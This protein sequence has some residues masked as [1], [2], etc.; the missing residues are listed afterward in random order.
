MEIRVDKKKTVTRNANK[1]NSHGT[2][3]MAFALSSIIVISC[4]YSTFTKGSE[5]NCKMRFSFH[6]AK[7]L[8][9]DKQYV[10]VDGH[11]C[12][13]YIGLKYLVCKPLSRKGPET[14]TGW[15]S[16]CYFFSDAMS[17]QWLR[18]DS[19]RKTH[20][21]FALTWCLMTAHCDCTFHQ[22]LPYAIL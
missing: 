15:E 18:N 14:K 4:V 20:P 5:C 16:S 10:T 11:G 22:F 17:I 1:L 19:P 8:E 3:E 9:M 13:K 6:R 21:H 2:V 7:E 12:F